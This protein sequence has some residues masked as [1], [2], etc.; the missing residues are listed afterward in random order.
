MISETPSLF[1]ELRST[2]V[3]PSDGKAPV[4]RQAFHSVKSCPIIRH[5][6]QSRQDGSTPPGELSRSRDKDT[7][8]QTSEYVCDAFGILLSFFGY[9][10][11]TLQVFANCLGGKFAEFLIVALG[12]MSHMSKAPLFCHIR[13]RISVQTCQKNCPDVLQPDNA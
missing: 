9:C 3:F 12:K 10:S 4:D 8:N 5:I 2:P 13:D 1:A 6:C 7:C 11:D